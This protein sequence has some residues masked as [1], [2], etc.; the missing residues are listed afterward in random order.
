MYGLSNDVAANMVLPFI[1]FYYD[2]FNKGNQRFWFLLEE[3][4]HCR[5]KVLLLGFCGKPKE[6]STL[7][8]K[9]IYFRGKKNCTWSVSVANLGFTGGAAQKIFFAQVL[10][11]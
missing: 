9:V 8:L 6:S 11:L 7:R 3:I 4:Y 5:P 2:K 10:K 1:Q